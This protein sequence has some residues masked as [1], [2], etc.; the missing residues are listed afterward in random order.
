[1]AYC[2]AKLKSCTDWDFCESSYRVL[3]NAVRL[4]PEMLVRRVPQMLAL[5]V[6]MVSDARIYSV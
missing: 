1:M 3:E 4:M 5:V 6:S 2:V